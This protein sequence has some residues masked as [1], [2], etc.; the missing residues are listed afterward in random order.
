[1][2]SPRDNPEP[3]RHVPTVSNPGRVRRGRHLPR[4][5]HERLG[6]VDLVVL[7]LV[8]RPAAYAPLVRTRFPHLHRVR[9][10]RRVAV[11]SGRPPL[12]D[13]DVLGDDGGSDV[14]GFAGRSTELQELPLQRAGELGSMQRALDAQFLSQRGAVVG[15]EGGK[16][17]QR[18]AV[19]HEAL[20]VLGKVEAVTDPPRDLVRSQHLVL[21]AGQR[22]HE[23]L[24]VDGVAGV[25]P[26]DALLHRAHGVRDLDVGV[27]V[28]SAD[29][30]RHVR[31]EL[32]A[33]DLAVAV[34]VERAEEGS[35]L[36]A[37]DLARL[38][39]LD[40]VGIRPAPGLGRRRGDD[41][42][43]YDEERDEASDEAGGQEASTGTPPSHVASCIFFEVRF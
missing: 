5:R 25:L 40:L 7:V 34:S 4:R 37:L 18:D 14:R 27:E 6:A 1:M 21:G 42:N 10:N 24:G 8:R 12:D 13:D 23:L 29:A 43:R 39:R 31:A 33:A 3:Q 15:Q 26:V 36:L 30:G 11:L 32:V 17:Q 20:G 41:R 19:R 16:V 22:H 2:P 28:L 35:D 9:V 38:A